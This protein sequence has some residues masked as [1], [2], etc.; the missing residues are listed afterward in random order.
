MPL[1]VVVALGVSYVWTP[2]A[3]L[4]LAIPTLGWVA[5]EAL[6]PAAKEM[7]KKES[8]P[9]W[10][11]LGIREVAAFTVALLVTGILALAGLPMNEGAGPVI[12]G[13]VLAS[14]WYSGKRHA[15]VLLK[16]LR[17]HA[18]WDT[19]LAYAFKITAA[20]ANSTPIIARD[21]GTIAMTPGPTMFDA[22]DDDPDGIDLR[23]RRY[24]PDLELDPRSNH[25]WAA[26]MHVTPKTEAERASLKKTGG[27]IK[28]I[29]ALN[30]TGSSPIPDV[31][32]ATPQSVSMDKSVPS[33]GP[34]FNLPD[35]RPHGT[36]T[37]SAG[38]GADH[39]MT[40]EDFL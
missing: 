14:A 33:L 22:I 40:E 9:G 17:D 1:L 15:D 34:A 23:L 10:E 20:E 21:D 25:T 27:R 31:N 26:L 35:A 7:N 38:S 16:P 32:A 18:A 3:G 36:S 19:T 30:L 37:S 12:C 39:V 24:R 13:L 5:G 6:K 4:A 28:N 11:A 29:E 2:I 8:I